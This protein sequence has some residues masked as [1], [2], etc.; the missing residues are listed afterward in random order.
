[1]IELCL[2]RDGWPVL[3]VDADWLRGV[4]GLTFLLLMLFLRIR[5]LME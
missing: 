5:Q 1:M 4:G 3:C 2:V